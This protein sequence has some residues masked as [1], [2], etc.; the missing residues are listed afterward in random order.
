MWDKMDDEK[1]AKITAK[2]AELGIDEKMVDEHLMHIFKKASFKLAKLRLVL[3][4]KGVDDA[5]VKE[6]FDK[7]VDKA[8]K[9]D[10][11]EFK[12]KLE[13]HKAN[14]EEHCHCDCHKADKA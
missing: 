6:L 14:H 9:K 2:L 7:L 3:N 11:A 5:K 10:L 13:E 4:D 8:M 1:K 12:K